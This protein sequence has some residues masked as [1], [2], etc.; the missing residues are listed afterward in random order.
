MGQN[1]K[2][3]VGIIGAGNW[4]RRGHLPVLSLLPEFEVRGIFARRSGAAADAA[5]D[6]GVEKTFEDLESLV[7]S[8]DVDLVCALNT[9]PQHEQAIR[10][11]VSAGKHVYS[12]WPLTTSTEVALDLRNAANGKGVKHYVGL[13]RRLA[14]VAREMRSLLDTGYIGDVRSV[15]LHVSVNYFQKVLPYALRW[16]APPENFSSLLA[17]YAGHFLDMIFGVT[18]RPKSLFAALKNNFPEVTVRET[19]E[20]IVTSNADEIM[21]TFVLETGALFSFHLEGAKH[22]NSGVRLDVTGFE[23]DLVMTNTSAFGEV[24]ED[25]VLEGARGDRQPLQR[26]AISQTH[27][28]L[29]SSGLPSSVT[30]LG[31]NYAAIAR[32]ILSNEGGVPTFD[33]GIYFQRLIDTIQQSASQGALL[34]AP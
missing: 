29:E 23:G 13:Q 11:A 22:N 8:P 15:R 25:Y 9:A 6:F 12:E 33:D 21:I 17:I 24:G 30:E 16:T 31:Y 32:N 14:P 27:P 26:M 19:G 18:G 1:E 5:R 7:A 34:P 20:T 4:A 2:I 10:A 28:L 3:G